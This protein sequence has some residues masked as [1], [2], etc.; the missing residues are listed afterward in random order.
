MVPIGAPTISPVA[1]G[2]MYLGTLVSTLPPLPLELGIAA[3]ELALVVAALVAVRSVTRKA[4]ALT[5]G[6]RTTPQSPD[7]SDAA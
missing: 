6:V 2:V 1:N 3:V 7:L 5:R 4:A